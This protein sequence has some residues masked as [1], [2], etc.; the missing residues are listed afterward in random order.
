MEGF[1]MPKITFTDYGPDDPFY[2]EGPQR[3]SPHWA[4]ALL[5]PKKPTPPH[6]A[7]AQTQQPMH[8]VMQKQQQSPPK[9]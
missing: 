4:W 3:Y 6:V 1:S 2:S 7:N 9:P 8:P 5:D